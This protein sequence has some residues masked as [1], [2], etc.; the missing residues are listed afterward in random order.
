MHKDI[1]IKVATDFSRIPGA[2]YPEEG[3]FSG[4]E[5][6]QK[7]L[8][9][10]LQKA[11]SRRV[12]LIIDLDGTAGLGTSFLEESFGGLI[13]ENHVDYKVLKN[14]IIIISEEDPDYKEEIDNYIKDAYDKEKNS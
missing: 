9:P 2:R 10:S 5:F 12:K 13:R 3:D 7:K 11:I 6:R 4:Q 1:K 14:T 8:Y